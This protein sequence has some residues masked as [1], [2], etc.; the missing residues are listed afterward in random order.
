MFTDIYVPFNG[1]AHARGALEHARQ[2]AAPLGATVVGS[3]V[4]AAR[5]HESRF[6]ALESGLPEPLRQEHRLAEQRD[7]HESLSTSGLELITDS[8]LGLMAARC[9][10]AHV[11][12]RGVT[13]E[14]RNWQALA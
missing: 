4:Y 13:L 7:I 1:S 5:L 10:T 12:F 11:P 8:Y 6:R 9:A 14:G 3:H 2:L